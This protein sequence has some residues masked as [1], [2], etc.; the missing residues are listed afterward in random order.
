[1]GGRNEQPNETGWIVGGLR[2]G[3]CLRHFPKTRSD[4]GGLF[5]NYRRLLCEF[6]KRGHFLPKILDEGCQWS[7]RMRCDCAPPT[8]VAE[9]LVDEPHRRIRIVE[10]HLS[11]E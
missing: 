11:N 7:G 9:D 3:K 6:G 10:N 8:Q 2:K 5:F 4:R 1:M